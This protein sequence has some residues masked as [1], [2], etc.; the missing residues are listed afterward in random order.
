MTDESYPSIDDL[1][2]AKAFEAV[3]DRLAS[4]STIKLAEFC[5]QVPDRYEILKSNTFDGFW[6]ARRQAVSKY[7]LK[8]QRGVCDA[9]LTVGHT[10]YLLAQREKIQGD[11]KRYQEYLNQALSVHSIHAAQTWL[12]EIVMSV[13][14]PDL[15]LIQKL[16]GIFYNQEGLAKRHGTPGYL[17]VAN[18]YFYLLNWLS[19]INKDED[20]KEWRIQYEGTVYSLW[21]SLYLAQ[22]AEHE[23]AES[24]YNAYFG[25]GLANSNSFKLP[26]IDAMMEKCGELSDNA[27][28]R[29]RA[30]Y[31]A[32]MTVNQ[33]NSLSLWATTAQAKTEQSCQQDVLKSPK[34]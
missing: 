29:T 13:K 21:K 6:Q 32:T 15:E 34:M 27:T 9:D 25:F 4:W 23:S 20:L 10:L 14:K 12:H 17:L 7:A 8:A 28:L 33:G 22:N 30:R 11:L 19:E 18:G 3:I 24:I 16:A 1:L 5:I 2:D 26:T 31:A